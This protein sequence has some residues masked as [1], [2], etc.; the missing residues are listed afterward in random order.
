MG[1]IARLGVPQLK[2]GREG[3]GDRREGEGKGGRGREREENRW[4]GGGGEEG[5]RST[6]NQVL[7]LQINL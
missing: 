4:G 6:V 2:E 7:T 1:Y 3:E 5:T